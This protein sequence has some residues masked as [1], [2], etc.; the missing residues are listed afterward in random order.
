[1]SVAESK[2]K[3]TKKASQ[4]KADNV[5]TLAPEVLK[6]ILDATPIEYVQVRD[7]VISD[8]NARTIPYSKESVRGLAESIA[9]I[10]LLQNLVVHSMPDNQ[11]GVACGGRR[12]TALALLLDEKRIQADAVIPVK[13]VSRDVAAAA[14]VAENEQRAAM[15][16]AEQITGFRTLAEMGKT[17]AQIG[18]EL[19]FGF[20]HVQRMLK[21]SG[22]AP[23]LLKLLA[24][25]E[26]DVEQC[27]ALC[28]END[29]SRQVAVYES[30]KKEWG[31]TP[32]AALKR[33]ITESEISVT[34]PRFIF[35]G[36]EAYEAAGGAVREDLFSAQDG[37]A[38]VDRVLTDSLVFEKLE[39]IAHEI[40]QKEGWSWAMG[41]PEAVSRHGI[42]ANDYLLLA[43]PDSVFMEGD[44]QRLDE[45]SDQF[46]ALDQDSEEAQAVWSE[47]QLIEHAADVRAWTDE[48]K[49]GA[50]VVVSLMKG[51]LYVQRGVCR[52]ADLPADEDEK[53]SQT[54]TGH[55]IHVRQPDAAE[56]ISVPLLTKMSSE[57]TLAVQ[58]ALM[59]QPEKAVALMVWRM[60]TSIFGGRSAQTNPFDVRVEVSHY[61]LTGEAPSGKEG[62]AY[63]A[64]MTEKDRLAALL[65]QGWQS[66][67]T[68]FFSLDG[69]VLMSL[70]AFCTACS[71][72][73]VQTRDMGHTSRSKLDGLEN[74][75]GFQLRDWWDPTKAGYF[76][77]LKHEQ[78]VMSLN[79]AG[80]TGA[81]KDAEKMKKGDAAEHAESW[82]KDTRWV[83]SWLRAPLP[84]TPSDDTE[85]V[86]TTLAA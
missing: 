3:N 78:I 68:S 7:L 13:R 16:P 60:C 6:S 65:P 51:E 41:R 31:H 61:T 39:Q 37:A 73:G 24:E 28:L 76:S 79:D 32:A 43:A 40:H 35:V 27:Q 80:L 85:T 17:P 46:N 44:S 23:S 81:A 33:L 62:K 1:M 45:L 4:K 75:I 8:L 10:G 86:N 63:L 26:L 83:P 52:K 64:L 22:L 48:L 71:V 25:D 56:G 12:T 69:G 84:E 77:S 2:A 54:A 34:D 11:S 50:G 66:D 70:I 19:G 58:A 57:R 72:N 42:D 21:L 47:M 9:A 29:P 20:R 15:H 38:T 36:R 82:L 55:V 5:Q 74:A 67:F 18:D 30:V 49:A 59:Q 14:S 53:E